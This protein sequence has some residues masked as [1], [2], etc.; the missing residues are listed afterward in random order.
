MAEKIVLLYRASAEIE[1]WCD[2]ANR[3]MTELFGAKFEVA[4]TKAFNPFADRIEAGQIGL[5]FIPEKLEIQEANTLA[6]CFR[7]SRGRPFLVTCSDNQEDLTKRVPPGFTVLS[8]TQFSE[9]FV[10]ECIKKLLT[11]T[12]AK[13]A[14]RFAA[15]AGEK[16]RPY[17]RNKLGV[18]LPSPRLSERAT[19]RI[20]GR[21]SACHWFSDGPLLGSVS[22]HVDPNLLQVMTENRR[23]TSPPSPQDLGQTGE[24]LLERATDFFTEDLGDYDFLI[25]P[26]LRLITMAPALTT[27]SSSIGRN[28]NLP[29]NSPS[30]PLDVTIEY[31]SYAASSKE[32][33][34][35]SGRP[36]DKTMD[37]RLANDA[38]SESQSHLAQTFQTATEVGSAAEHSGR[39]YSA[40]A[41][42]HLV[43]SGRQGALVVAIELDAEAASEIA[44]R[45]TKDTLDAS[46]P[47]AICTALCDWTHRLKNSL[48]ERC[49]QL[50]YDFQHI[51]SQVNLGDGLQYRLVGPSFFFRTQCTSEHFQV[52]LVIGAHSEHSSKFFDLWPLISKQ[53]GFRRLDAV[54]EAERR[55]LARD[56]ILV[57]A[58]PIFD[59]AL[60]HYQRHYPF[61]M[62]VNRVDADSVLSYEHRFAIGV[63]INDEPERLEGIMA[64]NAFRQHLG[65]VA[66]PIILLTEELSPEAAT[67]MH[68][69]P[70]IHI[71][72]LPFDSH[73]FF[74]LVS[75]LD[76][77]M[78]KHATLMEQHYLFESKMKEGDFS[79]AIKMCKPINDLNRNR[80]WNAMRL[81]RCHFALEELEEAKQH[82]QKCFKIRPDS[83]EVNSLLAR[84]YQLQGDSIGASKFVDRMARMSEI[85]LQNLIHWGGVYGERGDGRKAMAA[86]GAALDTDPNSAPAQEGLLAAA[87]LEGKGE[88]VKD[89]IQQQSGTIQIAR[90]CNLRGIAAANAGN[91]EV[92]ERLYGNAMH[93]L[94][95]EQDAEHKLWMN[96]GLCMKKK[97]DAE[98]ALEYFEKCQRTAPPGYDRVNEWVE[99]TQQELKDAGDSDDIVI[100]DGSDSWTPPEKD[101]EAQGDIY[102]SDSATLD[103]SSYGKRRKKRRT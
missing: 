75:E 68:D 20:H 67:L 91:F 27:K 102:Q 14:K 95:D 47:N 60:D 69:H 51:Q 90:V 74:S 26:A 33:D 45:S 62:N 83:L 63:I 89:V 17:V 48:L 43:F 71:C 70:F 57:R 93:L 50:G 8:K 81:A 99:R 30:G 85:Y 44:T 34:D 54:R 55:E 36:T 39:L 58:S 35:R 98:K 53:K 77:W 32:V 23:G 84:I 6:G 5:I 103:Y 15:Q 10:F 13:L 24:V 4:S 42:V 56:L 100:A 88:L 101:S 92:A 28:F 38:L 82:A 37:V 87:L 2:Q 79:E 61:S 59:Q 25:F 7:S 86:Y 73:A 65:H 40:Y 76:R 16:L 52:N 22:I 94:P 41:I 97:G 78:T 9:P 19:T 66:V 80:F 21:I 72:L 31:S 29:F 1:S 18:E 46:D 12:Q 64:I 49:R 11:P 96:L 3:R